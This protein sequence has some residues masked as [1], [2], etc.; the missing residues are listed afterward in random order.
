MRWSRA[1]SPTRTVWR[2]A[3]SISIGR[4]ARNAR[5]SRKVIIVGASC[6]DST[7]LLLNSTSE[8]YPNGLGNSSDVIGRYL[9]EQIRLNVTGFLP[10]LVGTPD[11]K[12]PRH[13]RRA[14]L[15]AALQ[16]SPGTQTRLPARVRRAVLE[17]GREHLRRPW[18]VGADSRLR[19]LVEEGDQASASRVVRDPSVRRGAAVRAQPRHRRS[20]AHRPLRRAAA[21]DRLPDRRE[22]AEDDRAHGRH[23]RGDRQGGRRRAG[24]LQARRSSMRW[25]RR[26]TSTAP[27][28]WAPIRNA[29]RSTAS[30]RCTT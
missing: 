7:R 16:S 30:T 5:R 27:A 14:H 25:D 17:H 13:R 2:A 12:R 15:H 21:E 18:R 19:R 4:P 22:R 3:C 8:R 1:S 6:V 24:E 23:R 26:S 10:V 20:G 29:R 28:A 11:A 9:C